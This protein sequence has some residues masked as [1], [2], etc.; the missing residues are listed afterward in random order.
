MD[1]NFNISIRDLTPT[2]TRT[3][4]ERTHAFLEK[5][6][7]GINFLTEG[8]PGQV[9]RLARFL[10]DSIARVSRVVQHAL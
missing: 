3:D 1:G 2:S 8:F 4:V 6:L 9:A 7:A 5:A 10:E